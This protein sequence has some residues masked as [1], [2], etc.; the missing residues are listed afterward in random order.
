MIVRGIAGFTRTGLV[1]S[2]NAKLV[3]HLFFEA[4]DFSFGCRIGGLHYLD[5]INSEFVL[6][7]DSVVSDRS[8][9]VA[10]WFLPFQRYTDIIIVENLRLA[11]FTRLVCREYYV[12]LIQNVTSHN[13]AITLTI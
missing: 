4:F 3:H 8:A 5:P 6:Y 9:T 7:L 12:K 2:T 10:L 1:V 13:I 11:R